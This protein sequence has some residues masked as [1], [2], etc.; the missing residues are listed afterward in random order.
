LLN[1]KISGI[2]KSVLLFSL[3]VTGEIRAET[4]VS[5]DRFLLKVLDRAISLQDIQYQLRNFKAVDCIF[6]DAL[7]IM[8]LEKGFIKNLQEF[9]TRYPQNEDEIRRYLHNHPTILKNIR[10]LFKLLRYAED[11]QRVISPKLTQ[12]IKES[13]QENKCD[14]DILHQ[15]S[16]KT[17]FKHL[18]ELEIYLR[19]RYE[20]QLKANKSNFDIIRPSIDLFVESLDKQFSH[21]YYW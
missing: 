9:L 21:E 5:S 13:S 11:Q 7:I 8:Y 14:K 12:L 6:S 17:N 20:G 4:L 19:S 10:I 1:K 15:D 2:L 16:L 3:L 18:L